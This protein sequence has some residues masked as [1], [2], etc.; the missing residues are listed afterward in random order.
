MATGTTE[1]EAEDD[2]L[3]N[4]EKIL[5]TG[6]TSRRNAAQPGKGGPQNFKSVMIGITV[7]ETQVFNLDIIGILPQNCY[8]VVCA[9]EGIHEGYN[10]IK[11]VSPSKVGQRSKPRVLFLVSVV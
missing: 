4:I 6:S 3:G 9:L 10:D 8:W 5:G 2:A 7:Q 1:Y 11:H